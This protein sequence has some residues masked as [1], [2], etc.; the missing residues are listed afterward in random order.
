MPSFREIMM[1]SPQRVTQAPTRS[2]QQ[3]AGQDQLLSQ[4]LQ[5]LSGNKFDFAPIA[6]QART[7]FQQKTIPTILDRFSQGRHSGALAGALSEAGAGLDEGLAGMESKYNLQQQGLL[8]NMAQLGLGSNFE[9]LVNPATSGLLQKLLPQLLGMGGDVLGQS[10]GEGDIFGQQSNSGSQSQGQS[11][12]GGG[13]MISMLTK[14]L[15]F[16]I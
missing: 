4:S 11:K 2:V 3:M 14:L 5:G 12:S 15:P 13:D 9:N 7:Q 16:L 6:Q 10:M 8:K 1:G